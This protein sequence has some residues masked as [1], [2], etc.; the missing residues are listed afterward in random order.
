M[1]IEG[2]A[3]PIVMRAGMP[4]IC[5]QPSEIPAMRQRNCLFE[6]TIHQRIAR[7]APALSHAE[8]L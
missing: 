4:S 2:D 8:G 1:M 5:Q 3:T 6:A 7:I